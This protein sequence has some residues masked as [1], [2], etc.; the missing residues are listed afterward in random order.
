MK[1]PA[2]CTAATA[3]LLAIGLSQQASALDKMPVLSLELAKKM[4]AGCEAKG[5]G[6]GLENEYLGRRRR[7]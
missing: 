1:S 6:N 2:I 3:I 4:A 5:Q 7:R